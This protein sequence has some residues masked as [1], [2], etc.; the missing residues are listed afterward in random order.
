M[1]VLDRELPPEIEALYDE[2]VALRPE[3]G[4]KFQRFLPPQGLAVAAQHVP[5]YT[6]DS[7]IRLVPDY[8]LP[9]LVHVLLHTL[10]F[11]KGY[12]MATTH[13]GSDPTYASIAH[14]A[15]CCATH[16]ALS[17]EVGRRPELLP[18]WQDELGK[19]P[20]AA[21]LRSPE[22]LS[23]LDTWRL[24]DAIAEAVPGSDELRSACAESQAAAWTAAERLLETRERCRGPSALRRFHA[25]SELVLFYD[26]LLK[27]SHGLPP[28]RAVLLSLVVSEPQLQRPADRMV[29]VVPLERDIIGFQ[30]KQD[31]TLFHIRF[32]LPGRQKR[33]LA[34]L[35]TDLRLRTEDF[36]N[37][38]WVPYTVDLRVGA[39]V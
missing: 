10:V 38:Y 24:A 22:P 2:V 11:R 9:S 12:P 4:L 32:A 21:G 13:A 37:K 3:S 15:S 1:Q 19:H 27:G 18:Y 23:V 36:L 26:E 30:H 17:E 34:E 25:M 20:R 7:E 33:E 31:R 8:D 14:V 35:R 29:E 6:G 28:S 5:D 39:G 16:A